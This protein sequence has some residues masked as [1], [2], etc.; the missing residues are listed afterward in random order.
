MAIS[1]QY[2]ETALTGTISSS[3]STSMTAGDTFTASMTDRN[4]GLAREPNSNTRLFSIGRG[5]ESF[6]IFECTH[7]TTNGVTTFTIVNR[8]LP[9]T[10]STTPLTEVTA[11]VK[12]HFAG[13]EIS[14]VDIATFLNILGLKLS[15]GAA[16]SPI[17]IDG[18]AFTFTDDGVTNARV[19]ADTTARDAAITSPA[20][21]MSC[22]VTADGAF[23]DYQGGAWA[24]RAS[25]STPNASTTVAGKVELAT[26]SENNAGTAT[27][28]TGASLVATPAVQAVTAQNG[29]WVYAASASV[30]DTYTATITPAPSAYASG[31]VFYIRVDTANTGAAT[32]NLNS[33]GAKTIKK[34]DD[35]DLETGDVEA[36]MILQLAYDATDDV[37]KML[38]PPASQMSTANSNTL[39]ASSSS[40]ASALHTHTN[41]VGVYTNGSFQKNIADAST[42]Q[43]I[44]H[45]LARTPKKIRV[46][47]S[48]DNANTAGGTGM[49]LFGTYDA[50]GQNCLGFT[51]NGSNV[52]TALQTSYSIRIQTGNGNYLLGFINNV[53]S[54]SFDI[55]WTKT[56]SPTGTENIIW[57]AEA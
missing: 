12:S 15:G 43:T 46:F 6:E 49:T 13:D 17:L 38:N 55:V 24:S 37:F 11:N 44:N 9:L 41:L 7:T 30:S 56:G 40:D 54:T 28:G 4:T 32:M 42:T 20:N 10:Y 36:G 14:V 39:T 47:Y 21:G 18:T 26:Q 50:S 5:T 52:A 1:V 35:Q 57:E 45:G 31:Q 8:G 53:T 23:Y 34:F 25:G 51:F 2:A 27:G 19:F 33:L 22:Y 29:V 16:I 3:I 48:L